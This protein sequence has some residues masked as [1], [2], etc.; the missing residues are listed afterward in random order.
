MKQHLGGTKYISNQ[1]SQFWTAVF[2]RPVLYVFYHSFSR[3]GKTNFGRPKPKKSLFYCFK[4]LTNL[5]S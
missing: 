1:G 5:E 3:A 2:Y 4:D